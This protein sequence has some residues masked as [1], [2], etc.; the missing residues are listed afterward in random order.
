MNLASKLTSSPVVARVAP[1]ACFLLL[2][3]A[4][5]YAGE[6]GRYWLYL[7]K[8]LLAAWMLWT[9]RHVVTEMRWKLTWEGVVVGVGVFVLW[10]GLDPLLVKLGWADSYPKMKLSGA[11]WNPQT[12]FGAGSVLA[13]FFIVVRLLGSTLVVPP[14]EEVFFRSFFYRYL[15]RVD[16]Q[17][18]PLGAWRP[19]PFLVTSTVFGF[20][21]R[22]W[23]AGILCGFAY[24]GLVC[25]KKRLGDAITAHAMTNLLLGLWV[26]TRGD[27]KF[28]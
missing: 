8:T 11:S 10:V 9:V 15:A 20:E 21:H 24:Q 18:V 6:V 26:V 3:F 22:E 5:G 4:Q 16:F 17:S 12:D 14:M 28:W 7:G 1:F 27:W 19:V 13:W 2:T 23:L 25:W